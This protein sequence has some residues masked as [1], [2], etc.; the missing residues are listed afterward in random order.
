MEEEEKAMMILVLI[1]GLV[2]VWIFLEEYHYF[3]FYME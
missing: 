2:L 3:G 1:V